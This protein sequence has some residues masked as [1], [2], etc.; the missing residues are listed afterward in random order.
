[1]HRTGISRRRFSQALLASSVVSLAGSYAPVRAQAVEQ[2]PRDPLTIVIDDL[3]AANRILVNEDVIDAFGHVS[4]RH[5][6]RPEHF[7]MARARPPAFVEPGDIM[8]FDRDGAPTGGDQRRPYV[9]RFIHTAIY[10]SRPDV[11][12]V[13]HHHSGAIIPFS[14]SDVPLRALSHV[15]GIIGGNVA[16]WDIAD[17][18]GAS[19]NLMVSD[20]EIGRSLART[21]GEDN[22][23]LMRGH[24][25]AAAGPS[26]RQATIAAIMLS[27]QATIM[28]NAVALGGNV[29][30]LSPGEVEETAKIFSSVT[31]GGAIERTWEF[32]CRRAGVP[33]HENGA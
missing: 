22:V 8:E 29:E 25:A 7:L 15:G 12:S 14:V 6:E 18:V 21:M 16:V 13:V 24:G 27:E 3:I 28:Q 4:A 11:R 9:E 33:F 17:V 26:I 1:M 20:L 32:W 23:V 19:S 10:Q 31:P 30:V 2:P 5:P